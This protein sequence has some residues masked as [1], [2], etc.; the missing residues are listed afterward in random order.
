MCVIVRAN[1]KG[2]MWASLE[3]LAADTAMSRASVKRSVCLIV[4]AGLMKAIG[5]RM[6][7]TVYALELPE[8]ARL[9]NVDSEVM[10]KRRGEFEQST[11][12]GSTGNPIT[13]IG[14]P[15]QADKVTLSGSTGNPITQTHNPPID[16]PLIPPP[17]PKARAGAA[18]V[19]MN[20][21][22]GGEQADELALGMDETEA[23]QAVQWALQAK[24]APGLIVHRFRRSERPWANPSGLSGQTGGTSNLEKLF[25]DKTNAN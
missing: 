1:Q 21:G 13:L 9:A 5:R 20:F 15:Y 6:N 7:V 22:M 17:P 18:V 11:L 25:A 12:S 23:A 2:Q 8:L 19:L 16:Q 4:A 24:A 10:R 14:S 3:T